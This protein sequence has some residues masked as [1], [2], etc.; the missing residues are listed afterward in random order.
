MKRLGLATVIATV[1]GITLICLPGMVSNLAFSQQEVQLPDTIVASAPVALP[2]QPTAAPGLPGEALPRPFGTSASDNIYSQKNVLIGS[3]GTALS[4][5]ISG[6][7]TDANNTPISGI[8]I[9][10]YSSGGPYVTIATTDG[11]GNY[12]LSGLAWDT[13]DIIPAKS[14]YAFSPNKRTVSV[15]PSATG[16]NFTAILI[17]PEQVIC[18]Q[19]LWVNTP[20]GGMFTV[21]QTCSWNELILWQP[22]NVSSGVYYRVNNPV[23]QS[24]DPPMVMV[25]GPVSRKLVSWSSF[26]QIASCQE[27]P[28]PTSTPTPPTATNTPTPTPGVKVRFRGTIREI[29][30]GPDWGAMRVQVEEVLSGPPIS[31][32]IWVNFGNIAGCFGDNEVY[33]A[34]VGD[35]VEVYGSYDPSYGVDACSPGDYIYLFC[36]PSRWRG[37][38][39]DN[40]TLSGE[41]LFARC[42]DAVNFDWGYNAPDPLLPVDHFSVRWTNVPNFNSGRYRFHTNTD[43]GVR[44]WVD[45]SLL[46]DQWHNQGATEYTAEINLSTGQHQ[47][48][49]EYYENI[50]WAGAQLWWEAVSTPT[51]SPTSTGTR[52]P[53]RTPTITHTPTGTTAPT[54]TP[55]RTPTLSP[56]PTRTSPPM[57]DFDHASLFPEPPPNGLANQVLNTDTTGATVAPDD[58]DM[59][60]GT[61]V[62]SNTV[63]YKLVPSYYGLVRV[64]T[65]STLPGASSNYNTVLAVFTGQRGSLHRITCNDDAPGHE[66]L[67]ELTFEAEAGQTYYIE[68]ADYD[69]AP[70]GGVL[71]LFVNYVVSPKTWTLMFYIAA[72]NDLEGTLKQQRDSLIPAARNLNVNIVALWDDNLNLF[73]SKYMVFTPWGV[74]E[75]S[76]PELNTGDPQTLQDFVTWAIQQYPAN[77]YALIISNHGHGFSGTSVDSY[78]GNAWLTI[79]ET[80]QALLG[81]YP[82]PDII[83]MDACLMATLDS[84]YQLAHQAEYYVASESATWELRFDYFIT[85]M[86]AHR[87]EVPAIRS[88]TSPTELALAMA[89]SYVYQAKFTRQGQNPS[90]ISVIKLS[91][92][93]DVAV[94]ASDLAGL[95][96]NR[97]SAVRSALDS[98]WQDVQRFYEHYERGKLEITTEDR[99]ADLYHFASLV[100]QRITDTD[101]RGAAWNLMNEINSA[102]LFNESWSGYPWG[103]NVY[104]YHK[105]AYGI[106]AFLPAPNKKECYYNGAWLDFAYGTNWGCQGTNMTGSSISD[107]TFEWGPMLVEYLNQTNPSAPENWE[108]PVP[109]PILTFYQVYLPLVVKGPSGGSCLA[110]SPHPYPDN[111]DNTWM[112]INP[113]TNAASTRIHFSRLE[114]ESGYDYVYV[115]DANNNQ[116]NRFTGNYPSGVWSDPVP[117]RTVKVQLTSDGSVTAWG[118][119]VDRIETVS[120]GGTATPT[121]TRT[122]TVT[123][124]HTPTPT[125]TPTATPTRTPTATPTPA[126]YSL[127]FVSARDG[128]R[129]IYR[130]DFATGTTTRITSNSAMDVFPAASPDGQ[131]VCFETNRT[132]DLEIF[133]TDRDGNNPVNL[134]NESGD[135]G[136]PRFSPDGR[137]IA[138]HRRTL[139]ETYFQIWVMNADGTNKRRLTNESGYMGEP[140]WFPDGSKLVFD[141][142]KPDRNILTVNLDGTGLTVINNQPGE[143]RS[144]S[145][146]PDGQFIYYDSSEGGKFQLYRM[147]V[148]GSSQTQ[149]TSG[150]ADNFLPQVSPDGTQLAFVSNRDGGDYEIYVS[151]ADGSNVQ[152]LTISVGV[153]ELPSWAN[154]PAPLPD[155]FLFAIGAQ[156]PVGQLDSPQGVAVAFD[157]TV[158]VADTY[159]HR[160][161]R[162]STTGSFLGKWGSQGSGDGQFSEPYGVA[163][164]PDGTVYVADFG[165]NR[166]QRFSAT[167]SFLGQWGSQGSGDGQFR[168]PSGVAVASDGTVYVADSGN[169]R[170]QRFSATG[171]FLGK[172]GSQGSGDGQFAWPSGVAV[173]PDGT[174]Y[175]VDEY[176]H[177][178]QRFSATGTFLGKWGAQ[179]SGDGQFLGPSGAA[180][181]S[182]GTV[183]V[184]DSGNYRIQRF[185]TTGSFLGKWGS[186]GSGDGQ[187]YGREGVAV[188][189]DGTVY[190]VEAVNNRIQRFTATGQFLGQWGA[191]G[192]GD[193]QFSVPYVVAVASDG[194]VYVADS[195]NKRIQRFSATGSFLGKW[196]SQG[197]GDGQFAWPS[198]VA[199]APDGTI[200]VV[201][202][203]NYRI[204]R[205]SATGT[206]LG[207]WGAQGSG[208]GQFSN[209]EG[210][211]V[212]PDGTVYVADTGNNRIQRF[213]AMGTLLGQWGSGGSGDGQFNA[214]TGVA[215][216]PDS[217]V[218]VAEYWNH[219]IQRFSATGTF[220]G[221]WGTQGSG[222]G[223]FSNPEGVAVA[224]DGTVYVADSNN[225][226]IQH[227][228]A[229]GQFLGKWGSY[230]SG[231]GQFLGPSGAAVASDGTVYVADRGNNR[232][233]AFGAAYPATWRGEYF[234]N[235]WLTEAPVLIRQDAAI[236]FNWGGGS[237]GP[238]VPS[239]NFSARWRR[240]VWFDAGTYRFTLGLDDGGRLW[241]DDHLLIEAWQDPQAATFQ[242]DVTLSQGYHRVRLEYYEAGGAAGVHLSWTAL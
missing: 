93:T 133:C 123:S 91:E 240:Y 112:L 204:Q 49:M 68:V 38:Y 153:D 198:G 166:I 185:S 20:T 7:V 17:P 117:G 116:I 69:S 223:Q 9:I 155:K 170:I 130:Y 132:G 126:R 129:E 65:Y 102:V 72:N 167:G 225:D 220:L 213:S 138:Y 176:N 226:R 24:F 191:Q 56:T 47:V 134:T 94:A 179:G 95:L 96:K 203:Y 139:G 222:D 174:I 148:D 32:E 29:N 209:P 128:N 52:T 16:Q 89:E 13:Y 124:T 131:R 183:Y 141:G 227:F 60:C 48:R 61:G 232:I 33:A 3:D 150:T 6:R 127:F 187:F 219:R 144:P 64:S 85:G 208:D 63:W 161:Q 234:A 207:K 202:E 237:P 212:A 216:A 82:K 42:D 27:C 218:Y 214:P 206:F 15:P 40:Q 76:K 233:Q 140:A 110:E 146:S 136:M 21:L 23:F 2:E 59:G 77:H 62:N 199:V 197:S 241:V 90:T 106:S 135:D 35:R 189:F 103:G 156:A 5:S 75:I 67:S 211:A 205:F 88:D 145:V 196:G 186:Q 184:A 228:S 239:D 193:G 12:T 105:D 26:Q 190:V 78:S 45:G 83:Y 125:R 111:Y 168:G 173:A 224:S 215:A 143:Q 113:D 36:I 165:N 217:A 162:F 46:I 230:G 115:R 121:R 86:P 101:I 172:W 158:Y 54:R 39:Y 11:N 200:Y 236:D 192:S 231:D 164:A 142:D 159:N 70:G 177:R 4:E 43:D 221:K 163:V 22:S 178:I 118:F 182:D 238:G 18:G 57:D 58:P 181:A 107:T 195:G 157:G 104:W 229:T 10:A 120:T 160:I 119:C 50:G 137:L 53:T 25:Q 154:A 242:A 92:I 235:R 180:V 51:P 147:R 31:G 19:F 114:T 41:P 108:P 152:R 66:P 210:V 109:V 74:Q 169:N 73:G 34:R 175:V 1:F 149:L 97:M 55:T 37:E 71:S 80:D 81:V 28:A 30:Q 201:D 188:A 8:Y 79:K 99:A 14:G 98:I 87:T 171:S 122:P 44:L 100:H 151:N 84:A 194:T